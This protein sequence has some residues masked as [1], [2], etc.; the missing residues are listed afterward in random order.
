MK[1][2]VGG[3]N[4]GAEVALVHDRALQRAAARKFDAPLSRR[5]YAAPAPSGRRP[6]DRFN[7]ACNETIYVGD[8][9]RHFLI[10][11]RKCGHSLLDP[12][13]PD[14]FGDFFIAVVSKEGE[15]RRGSITSVRVAAMADRAAIL[16]R[17]KRIGGSL[18]E[19]RGRE[20]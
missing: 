9:P 4:L 8:Q 18:A 17:P 19:N 1:L 7:L 3:A 10:G 5:K 16:K 12:P 11:E 6:V 13:L 15:N 14:Q 20:Q 2:A